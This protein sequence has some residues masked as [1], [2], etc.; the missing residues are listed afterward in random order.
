MKGK[1][2]WYQ[3]VGRCHWIVFF[4][5][6]IGMLNYPELR[7]DIVTGDIHTVAVG[8]D[9]EENATFV[10]DILLFE[11]RTA[12]ESLELTR[13]ESQIPVESNM[14]EMFRVFVDGMQ[15]I[16]SSLASAPVP[17]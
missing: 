11:G 3:P 4:S 8:F 10:M 2:S 7:W 1:L 14:N 6:V 9:E 15:P 17:S 12:E 13:M 5:Y 16:G